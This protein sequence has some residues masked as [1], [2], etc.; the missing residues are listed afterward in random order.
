MCIPRRSSAASRPGLLSNTAL[1]EGPAHSRE[2]HFNARDTHVSL[3]YGGNV[4]RDSQRPIDV[5]MEDKDIIDCYHNLSKSE[6]SVFGSGLTTDAI[7]WS[8]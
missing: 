8:G 3:N 2:Y 1:L 4:L 5:G 7:D 6:R